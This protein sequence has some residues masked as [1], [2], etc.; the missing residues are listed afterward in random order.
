MRVSRSA[1]WQMFLGRLFWVTCL[2]F[3]TFNATGFSYYHWVSSYHFEGLTSPL[4][5]AKIALGVLIFVCFL[6][7]F[8]ATWRAKGPVGI[9]VTLGVLTAVTY[10]FW[11]FGI[12]DLSSPTVST[13][14][15]QTFLIVILAVGSIWSAVWKYFTGQVDVIGDDID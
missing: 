14:I 2:V 15:G 6:L 13:I 12:I 3:F 7:L 5:A 1:F 4:G 9:V 10:F 11:T 8:K